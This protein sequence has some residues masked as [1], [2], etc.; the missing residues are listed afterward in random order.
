MA[1]KSLL[2]LG[3]ALQCLAGLDEP[4]YGD[5]AQGELDSTTFY[6]K[7]SCSYTAQEYAFPLPTAMHREDKRLTAPARQILTT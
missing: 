3:S 4:C 1:Y 7:T 2:F 6:G 5:G